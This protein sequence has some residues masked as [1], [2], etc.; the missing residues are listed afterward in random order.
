MAD[1]GG[2]RR[3]TGTVRF[4]VTALATVAVLVVLTVAAVGV[5][6]AQGRLLT[7]S[8]DDSVR[9]AADR[10]ADSVRAGDVQVG[11]GG[12]DDD[13]DDDDAAVQVVDR[14]GEVIAATPNLAGEGL[15]ADPPVRNRLVIRTAG[16]LPHDDD[17]PFR[18]ASLRVDGPDG[19]VTVHVAASLDDVL[20]STAVLGRSLALGIPVVAL[21]LALVVWVLV[22][23]TLRSVERI[24]VEVSEITGSDLHR[25]VPLPASDDEIARLARTMNAMLD[26]VED[27]ADR[28]QRFVADASHELRSPL[29]RMRAELEVDLAHP[30]RSDPEATHRS[31]LEEATGL[32]R[33]VEDL[34][35]LA[36]TDSGRA[37]LPDEVVDLDDLVLAQARVVRATGGVEVRTTGVAAAQVRGDAGQLARALANLSDNAARHAATSVTFTVAERAGTAVVTVGDDGP[38]I[39]PDQRERVFERFARLDEARQTGAGGTGLGLAIAREIARRHGGTLVV[40]DGDRPGAVFE[41]SLPLHRPDA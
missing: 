33:L 5:V 27:A 8:L 20:E 40:A 32:Q 35:Q 18:V 13:D 10:V 21:L 30:D 14:D 3:V 9:Q 34:L 36:R 22:G 16:E 15:I 41:L 31:V 6:V 29:T 19:P 24:R 1:A 23:R 39:P 4:R 37:P 7:E 2:L 38:G 17:G 25:R 28:Q 11:P 12:L 26:R